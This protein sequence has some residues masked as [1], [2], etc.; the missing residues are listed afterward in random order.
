[1]V[2]LG[3]IAMFPTLMIRLNRLIRQHKPPCYALNLAAVMVPNLYL[4][5]MITLFVI[6]A[7]GI[8][9]CLIQEKMEERKQPV[10]LLGISMTCTLLATGVVWLPSLLR[11][12]SSAR[13]IGLVGST[14]SGAPLTS[15][16]TM[17]SILLCSAGVFAVLAYLDPRKC[18]QDSHMRS[19][20]IL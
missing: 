5:Y 16:Y 2:W 6:L 3:A 12:L 13:A 1:M 18:W 17:L 14:S 7:L 9:L 4:A 8:H 15:F 10:L 11:Y 19:L 20:L